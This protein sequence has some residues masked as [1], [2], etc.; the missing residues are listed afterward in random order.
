MPP[1]GKCGTWNAPEPAR[2]VDCEC[3]GRSHGR[4]HCNLGYFR[5]R[6]QVLHA[7]VQHHIGVYGRGSYGAPER[8][9]TN[10]K[11]SLAGLSDDT[12]RAC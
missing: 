2:R 7:R 1:I 5:P 11:P 12:T 10:S 4:R 9:D 6:M 3:D 8:A